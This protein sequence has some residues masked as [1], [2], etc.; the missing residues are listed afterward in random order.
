MRLRRNTQRKERHLVDEEKRKAKRFLYIGE[1]NRS[2]YER[3]VE[4]HRDIDACK[5]SSHMLRHLLAEHEEEEERWASIEFGKKIVKATRS[6]YERQVLESVIIQ[7]ERR[8]HLMNNKAEWNRCA[9]PRLT[10]KMGEVDLEKW[11]DEDR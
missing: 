1:T 10:T 2:G 8:H 5:T 7:K 6:A 11:R 4:H 3:G 9:L